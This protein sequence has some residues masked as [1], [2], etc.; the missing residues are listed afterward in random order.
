MPAPT[1][2]SQRPGR[3][4]DAL[5]VRRFLGREASP[6][7]VDQARQASGAAGPLKPRN[8]LCVRV[9]TLEPGVGIQG[10]VVEGRLLLGVDA[11]GR[12]ISA[13]CG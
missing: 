7:L 9:W 1:G 4:C 13:D 12:I 6:I 3:Y 8:R 5:P 10:V 2:L 11:S